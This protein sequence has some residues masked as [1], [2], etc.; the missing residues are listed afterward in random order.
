MDY[1]TSEVA[2]CVKSL[3]EAL[4]RSGK[5]TEISLHTYGEQQITIDNIS[6]RKDIVY[7]VR[8]VD[9]YQ[10]LSGSYNS[11]NSIKYSIN[12]LAR[13]EL[14]QY[15]HKDAHTISYRK[16]LTCQRN[17]V[18]VMSTNLSKT[19]YEDSCGFCNQ[20]VCY[21]RW[22]YIDIVEGAIVKSFDHNIIIGSIT[23]ELVQN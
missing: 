10:E 21:S 18:N 16:C 11:I 6:R 17:N 14:S 20:R 2:A 9:A 19:I 22:E 7:N 8:C 15:E 13:A 23:A 12:K 3:S 5:P 4:K 1:Y